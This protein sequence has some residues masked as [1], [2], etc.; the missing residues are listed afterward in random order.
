MPLKP[1][2]ASG[3]PTGRGRPWF[4]VGLLA[5]GTL[6]AP[7]IAR[8]Q[9]EEPISNEYRI[10]I[11]PNYPV[12][13]NLSGFG[14]LGYVNNPDKDYQLYY[15][16]FPGWN[17]IVKPRVL[18]IWGGLFGIFTDNKDK[19]DKF[20]LR[21][22]AGVKVFVPNDF[23]WNIYNF[24]R[25]EY[26]ATKDLDTHDWTYVNR[27]RTRFGVEFPLTSREHAWSKKTFYGLADVEPFYRFDH[28]TV[29][30]LRIRAGLGRVF[31]GHC[32]A[33]LI[34]H[35]QF[36]RPNGPLEYTDNIFRLNVKIGL[37]RGIL[38]RVMDMDFDE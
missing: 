20:E 6:G 38:P 33:E 27:V 32:R 21:P 34:Y 7:T 11:F 9:D 4:L 1:G 15:L 17:W 35:V 26:R 28:H 13:E 24:S 3:R 5:Y 14:Y 10:T 30:P 2:H 22:F 16:G 37:K 18:Q 31:A 8:A 36:T 23:K 19:A 25:Y 29:D 12:K